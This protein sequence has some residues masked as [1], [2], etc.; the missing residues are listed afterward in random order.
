MIITFKRKDERSTDADKQD[1][2]REAV[3]SNVAFFTAA[4]FSTSAHPVP[5]GI[6]PEALGYDVNR[7]DAPILMASLTDRDI[8]ALKDHEDVVAVEEDGIMHALP[9]SDY[10]VEGVPE[11]KAQTVPA[12][13]AQIKAPEGWGASQGLAIKV[14]I[15][16][17]GIDSDHPDLVA[18]LKAGKSFVPSESSTE[19][20][21]GHGTHCAGTVAAAFN[22]QGVVGVAPYAYLHPVKVL[23]ATGEGQWSW[24]IAAIDWVTEK[25][26]PRILSMSLGG[27]GAPAALEQM[28]DSAYD[29]GCLLVAAAGN[30]GPGND[31]V[32]QPASYDSVVAVSA[33]DSSDQIASFSSRGPEVELA[34]PG[35]NVLSTTQGGGYGNKSGTS[36][37]CPHVAGAAAMAWGGHRTTNNKQIRKLLQ[38]TAVNLGP[39]GRDEEYGFGRVDAHQAA[40]W[41]WGIPE[42]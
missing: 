27:G 39:T 14:F 9:T 38:M 8:A 31:T 1:I 10:T 32:G 7:Y 36:M 30:S 2:T 33:I 26:G 5:S 18:N 37:A 6:D 42:A 15:L 35:V 11:I 16:D 29:D 22:G 40:V 25:K 24:L 28:A 34:A 12:G 17:T 19:D 23:S 13:V 3:S 20:F 41:L 21:N 4:D